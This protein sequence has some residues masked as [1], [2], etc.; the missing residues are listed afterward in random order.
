MGTSPG[1]RHFS[2]AALYNGAANVRAAKGIDSELQKSADRARAILALFRRV[3]Y[4]PY[5]IHCQVF[6]GNS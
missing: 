5:E 6:L 3:R 2:A 1:L 4:R